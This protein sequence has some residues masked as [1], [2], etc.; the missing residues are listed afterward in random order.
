MKLAFITP[1]N[2]LKQIS[3]LGDIEFCLAPY[4][5]RDKKYKQYFIDAKKKEGRYVILDNGVAE[6][7]LISNE[8]LVNLAVEMKVDELIIPDVIGDN[9]QTKIMRKKFLERYYDI[10]KSSNIKIQS[11]IQGNSFGEYLGEVVELDC[12]DRIDVIG[13]PF[14]MNY[15]KFNKTND[16]KNCMFNRIMF[17]KF[18]DKV[19]KPI[20]MLGNNLS[21][22]LTMIDNTKVRSCDS[23]L[24]ARYGLSGKIW[25]W[26]DDDKPEKKL[27]I[28]DKMTK[29]QIKLTIEN[30]N[31]LRK[32]MYDSQG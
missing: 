31:K 12:D 13:V 19:E 4:A 9:K 27:N 28:T 7:D 1:T 3:S 32:E 5:L 11:V 16:R 26:D 29:E 20:H 22:E 21:I 18:I 24:M 2:A 10:L 14:R 8:K 23:K 6:G 17:L 25:D 30:I 15:C